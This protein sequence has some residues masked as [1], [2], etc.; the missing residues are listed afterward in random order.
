VVVKSIT[1]R[2]LRNRSGEVLRA[3][4][5]GETYEVTNHGRVVARLVPAGDEPGLR[6]VRAAVAR[7]VWSEL[8][9]QLV[10]GH[11]DDVLDE[12]RGE[13]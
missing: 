2:E 10:D 8:P 13:R 11:S 9:R 1:H 3:V 5:Q 4:A 7:P 12:L 6:P